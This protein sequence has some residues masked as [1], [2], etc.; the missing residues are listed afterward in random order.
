MY[1]ESLSLNPSVTFP[2]PEL[3]V[4]FVSS[5]VLKL[6]IALDKIAHKWTYWPDGLP[7]SPC[8]FQSRP[9]EPSTDSLIPEGLGNFRMS[10][11]NLVSSADIFRYGQLA[12]E[13]DFEPALVFVVHNGKFVDLD[14]FHVLVMVPGVVSRSSAARS[15][16]ANSA[17]AA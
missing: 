12:A 5:E 15:Q 11:R 2:F 14:R 7:A 9:H 3:M 4:S 13:V 1:R 8:V 6:R 10:E 17:A 16:S